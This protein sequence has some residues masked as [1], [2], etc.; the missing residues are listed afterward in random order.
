MLEA[1][2]KC[3]AIFVKNDVTGTV[4][5]QKRSGVDAVILGKKEEIANSQH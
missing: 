4:L 1:F 5:G 2:A 3:S